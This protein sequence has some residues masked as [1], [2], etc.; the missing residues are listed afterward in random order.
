[1]EKVRV[2]VLGSRF[3]A[4]LHLSNFKKLRGH[5]MEVVAVAARSEESASRFAKA[6]D[7]PKIYTDYRKLVESPDVDAV[8]VC[9]PTDLH[10]EAVIAAAEAG[11]HVICEKPLTGYFGKDLDEERVGDRVSRETM[12]REAMKGCQEIRSAVERKRITFCYAEDWVYAPAFVK[13]K[14]MVRVSGGI[15]MDIR[16]EESHSGSH[17]AYSRRWKTSGGGSLARMGSH[18]IGAVLHLKHFEGQ[19]REGKPIRG[20]SVIA[21]VGRHTQIPSYRNMSKKW[22]VSD[23]QDVEDWSSLI[24]EFEDSTHAVILSTD[25]ML[26]GTRNTME[27]YLSNAVVRAN[28]SPNNAVEV[29]APDAEIFGDEYLVEKLETKAGWNF[30]SPDEDWARGYPQELEDFIDAILD[31]REPLSGLDLAEEVVKVIY[32]GYLSAERGQR[33]P[34][35]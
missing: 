13:L 24:I 16:A 21:A 28:M 23:W 31:D 11:K 29:Y 20:G 27:A 22:I 8:D 15:V 6:F 4:H 33:V 18:P 34:L 26:G 9:L 14:R 3:S 7:I 17:A 30:A 25:G 5:R 32:S 35:L 12:L 1:M 10:K 2:G 19:I